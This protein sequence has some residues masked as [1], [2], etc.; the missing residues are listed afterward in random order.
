MKMEFTDIK[1]IVD[2]TMQQAFYR[3]VSDFDYE[4]IPKIGRENF[5]RNSGKECEERALRMFRLLA[6]P[7]VREFSGI[8]DLMAVAQHNGLATRLLD[9]TR[10]PLVALYFAAKKPEKDGALYLC[11]YETA[12]GLVDTA[13]EKPFELNEDL[14]FL[15]PFLDP[16]IE[17]QAGF[18]SIQRDPLNPFTKEGLQKIKIP[19]AMKPIILQ[20]LAQWDVKE[21]RL[22]PGIT[23]VAA[24]INRAL[25]KEGF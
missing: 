12:G 21:S 24:D 5:R 6:D 11:K 25:Q 9:W 14:W 23:S 22:F 7:Y 16:R 3:G 4:L 1:Q 13:K 17:A 18:F 10:N 8:W 19:Y 2:L 20:F 15:P